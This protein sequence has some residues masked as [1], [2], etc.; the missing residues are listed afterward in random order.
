LG[1]SNSGSVIVRHFKYVALMDNQSRRDRHR[2]YIRDRYRNDAAFR[3]R[4]K[5]AVKRTRLCQREAA[6]KVVIQAKSHGCVLCSESEPT[7][8]DFHHVRGKKEFSLGDVMRGRYSVARIEAELA[9]CIVVCANCHRKIHAG[10]ISSSE[11][12][13]SSHVVARELPGQSIWQLR[14]KEEARFSGPPK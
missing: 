6:R 14:S 9:K 8:L 2:R 3:E 1:Y 7:C 13:A 10:V 12:H 11:L 5:E 4:H